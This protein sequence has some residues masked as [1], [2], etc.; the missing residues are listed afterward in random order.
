[1]PTPV[2]G[3]SSHSFRKMFF[4]SFPIKIFFKKVSEP[5]CCPH[6]VLLCWKPQHTPVLLTPLAPAVKLPCSWQWWPECHMH[7]VLDKAHGSDLT[8]SLQQRFRL[9]PLNLGRRDGLQEMSPVGDTGKQGRS[10]PGDDSFIPH[11]M[12]ISFLVQGLYLSWGVLGCSFNHL[13]I[14]RTPPGILGTPK[15][16]GGGVPIWVEAA[17]L[18]VAPWHEDGKDTWTQSLPVLEWSHPIPCLHLA[19]STKACTWLWEKLRSSPGVLWVAHTGG[20]EGGWRRWLKP[21]C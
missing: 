21:A 14:P 2:L 8:A 18:Q 19:V 10:H 17:F 16:S 3:G 6:K 11:T 9:P 13:K 7:M 4:F 15:G 12:A 20:L 1:M 5:T